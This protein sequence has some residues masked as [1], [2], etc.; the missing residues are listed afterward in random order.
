MASENKRLISMEKLRDHLQELFELI[1]IETKQVP[2]QE[3]P[4]LLAV[5]ELIV[6]DTPLYTYLDIL[7]T[8]SIR[9]IKKMKEINIELWN[10]GENEKYLDEL[11][12]CKESY[13]EQ[14]AGLKAEI[15]TL[16]C[17]NCEDTADECSAS[18]VK[19]EEYEK[20]LL[21]AKISMI[22]EQI[23][24]R[25]SMQLRESIIREESPEEVNALK[26]LASLIREAASS[27][28]NAGVEI[29][30]SDGEFDSRIQTVS[31]TVETDATDKVNCVAQTVRAG[32]RYCGEIIRYQ[33]ILLYVPK[34]GDF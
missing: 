17:N 16:S 1:G 20:E 4:K 29:L 8:N 19:N 26:L 28:Q 14:I 6:K 3:A 7:D 12:K 30:E 33:E 9:A 2:V 32:Y 31:G 21:D 11:E 23:A 24:F 10:S 25:D 27:L 22:K 18:D 15:E 5:L 34:K 13:E